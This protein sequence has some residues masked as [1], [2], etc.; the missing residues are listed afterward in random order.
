ME[1]IVYNSWKISSSLWRI[2]GQCC[3]CVCCVK[4]IIEIHE[5]LRHIIINDSW[6]LLWK[7]PPKS[8]RWY[9]TLDP[10]TL[11]S[12]MLRRQ[13][14]DQMRGFL[15]LTCLLHETIIN[16]MINNDEFASFIFAQLPVR[17]YSTRSEAVYAR[18][19]RHRCQKNTW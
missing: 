18:K 5:M 16:P 9:I 19:I 11:R 6:I 14:A 17:G 2:L 12:T 13:V 15:G 7:K 4:K 10:L 8:K 1:K 3:V